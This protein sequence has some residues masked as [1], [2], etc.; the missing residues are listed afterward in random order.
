MKH[1]ECGKLSAK[2]ASLILIETWSQC[3]YCKVRRAFAQIPVESNNDSHI[4]KM[5][6]SPVDES[7]IDGK[8]IQ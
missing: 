2:T 7:N 1:A 4:R 8:K 5:R 3:Y 6:I